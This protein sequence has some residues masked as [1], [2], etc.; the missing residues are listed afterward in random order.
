MFDDRLAEF[1]RERLGGREIPE[2]LRIILIGHWSGDEELVD[3]VPV[4]LL[5]EGMPHPLR[6]HSYLSEKERADPEM[7]C[8]MAASEQMAEFVQLVCEGGKGWLGYWTHPDQPG[9]ELIP[10]ELDTEA[11]FWGM[12]GDNFAIACL[13]DECLDEDDEQQRFAELTA[14]AIA[15]GI[16]ISTRALDEVEGPPYIHDPNELNARLIEAERANL[17]LS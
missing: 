10:I 13:V 8:V 14:R 7:Q 2:D 16:P 15:L 12:D 11:Q 9:D 5:E 3:L 17:G 4:E 1:S 6:D